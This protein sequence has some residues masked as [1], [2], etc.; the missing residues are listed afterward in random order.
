MNE[1]QSNRDASDIAAWGFYSVITVSFE[2]DDKA[3]P[4]LRRLKELDSQHQV[5]MDEAV[6]VMRD[7]EGR[8]VVKDRVASAPLPNTIGGGL[9]GLLVGIIGGPLGMLIGGTAGVSVGT[10]LDIEDS[11]KTDSALTAISSSARPGHTT[12]LGI[13]R[14]YRREVVDAA[15]SR[16]GGTVLRRPVHDV[17]AEI[18]VAEQAQR[19]AKREARKELL[20][21]RRPPG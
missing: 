6:V 15:M 20:R 10:L 16:L 3:F 17:E 9:V 19:A 13:V 14:E 21:G 11:D 5:G 12:L 4:A 8:V 7:A 18:A 1:T 2:D